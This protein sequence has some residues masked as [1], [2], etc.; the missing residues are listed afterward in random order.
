MKLIGKRPLCML[1]LL[2]VMAA[3]L[4]V[5]APLAMGWILVGAAL[6][7]IVFVLLAVRTGKLAF[8]SGCMA[9]CLLVVLPLGYWCSARY[10][11]ATVHR[12]E[13]DAG[14]IHTVEGTVLERVWS[15]GY[16]SGFI[17]RAD[18]LDGEPIKADLLLDCAYPADFQ[19]GWRIRLT[20]ETARLEEDIN[21]CDQRSYYLSRG[22]VLQI[23]SDD[24]SAAEHLPNAYIPLSVLASRW[25]ED[26]SAR[27]RLLLGEKTGKLLSAL[28]LGQRSALDD[29]VIRD[30]KRLGLSHLLALSGLHLTILTGG[31][32]GLLRELPLGRR[33]RR[34]LQLLFVGAYVLLTGAPIS[35]VRAALMLALSS[36]AAML[37]EESDPITVLFSAAAAIVLVNPPALLDFGF[38]MSVFATLAMLNCRNLKLSACPAYLRKPARTLIATMAVNLMTLPLVWLSS[39]LFSLLSLPANLIFVPIVSL[40]LFAAPIVLLSG[41]ILA[42]P[43]DWLARAVLDVI[44]HIAQLRG[45]VISLHNP[46]AALLVFW[47]LLFLL[48]MIFFPPKRRSITWLACTGMVL[49]LGISLLW[50]QLPGNLSVVYSRQ[51]SGET[52]VLS[53]KGRTTLCDMGDG[54]Y[55]PMRAGAAYAADLGATEIETVFLTHYHTK[56][57]SGVLR[58]CDSMIVRNLFLPTPANSRDAEIKRDLEEIAEGAGVRVVVYADGETVSTPAYA[59]T[60]HTRS[61]LDRSAQPLLLLNLEHG[62]ER[63]TYFGASVWES[64]LAGIA[65]DYA[66]SARY[67]IFGEHGPV[68]KQ[69]HPLPNVP[70]AEQLIFATEEILRMHMAPNAEDAAWTQTPVILAERIRLCMKRENF[71]AFCK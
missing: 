2:A 12:L 35:V 9:V 18:S 34:I 21:G 64:D 27:L 44:H 38:W 60:P 28:F 7:G 13:A 36:L 31:L 59:L 26:L 69:V 5:W 10:Y 11:A 48:G 68:P 55:S 20:G 4:G 32:E 71:F 19:P 42:L 17:L 23:A 3:M 29:S 45:I 6:A 53:E 43:V 15:G 65:A 30:F 40:L 67:L 63:L 58:L 50:Q 62:E 37:W 47:V 61:Y 54:S 52:L 41:R 1:C 33:M 14:G 22:V 57:I 56:H 51:P 25:N 8:Y 46:G 70:L 49:C 24:A 66:A 39:G 16:Q